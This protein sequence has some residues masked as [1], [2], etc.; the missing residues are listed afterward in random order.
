ME[1]NV[2]RPGPAP[3]LQESSTHDVMYF[4]RSSDDALSAG[5][6]CRHIKMAVVTW[7]GSVWL[8]KAAQM[9]QKADDRK[10]KGRWSLVVGV[11]LL[12]T[13]S[14]FLVDCSMGSRH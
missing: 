7:R 12:Q 8:M 5:S 11:D 1:L 9:G 3:W 4:Q 14:T 2:G 13:V 10:R 6:C